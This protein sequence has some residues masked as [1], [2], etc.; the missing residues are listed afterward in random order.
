MG[1]CKIV[2]DFLFNGIISLTIVKQKKMKTNEMKLNK[3]MKFKQ[4]KK[5][6]KKKPV[7]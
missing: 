1:H 5:L 2:V 6:K 3:R 7:E 4:N